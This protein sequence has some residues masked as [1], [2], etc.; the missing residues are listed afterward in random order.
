MKRCEKCHE[1]IPE[2]MKICPHCGLLPPRLFPNFYLYAVL[3]CVA[4]ACAVYFRPFLGSPAYPQV[5]KGML[6]VS[7]SIFAVFAL[8]FIFVS[9]TVLRAYKNRTYKGKLTKAEVTRFVN[10]KKHIESGRHVYENGKYCKICG[11][12]K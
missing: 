5:A 3:S 8:V 12:K 4:I 10:M 1:Y 9:F 11:H 2:G 7:F 6:W